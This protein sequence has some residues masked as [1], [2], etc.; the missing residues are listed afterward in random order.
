VD[1]TEAD[2]SS[3][4]LALPGSDE[5]CQVEV[6]TESWRV[7]LGRQALPNPVGNMTSPIEVLKEVLRMGAWN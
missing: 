4:F 5:R 2:P 3:A 7:R 6:M 1:V